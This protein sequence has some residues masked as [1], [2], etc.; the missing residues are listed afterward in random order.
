MAS[1]DLKT[2][3]FIDKEKDS[4]SLLNYFAKFLIQ[5]DRITGREYKLFKYKVKGNKKRI[6]E[7][8]KNWKPF[9]I[10]IGGGQGKDVVLACF[11]TNYF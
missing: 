8:R 9:K 7:R 6:D 1:I 10:D 11:K 2:Q 4:V 5:S 3:F